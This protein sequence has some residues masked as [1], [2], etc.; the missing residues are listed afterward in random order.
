MDVSS[1]NFSARSTCRVRISVR[2]PMF[3]CPPIGPTEVFF[4]RAPKT[5]RKIGAR[6]ICRKVSKNIF[7]TFLTFFDVAPS[8]GPVCGPGVFCSCYKSVGPP[9]GSPE[10]FSPVQSVSPL[11]KTLCN[12]ETQIWLEMI[13]ARDA[14]SACFKG[15]RTT[16]SVSWAKTTWG[17]G[18]GNRIVR[19][20]GGKRTIACA[21][22]NHFWRAQKVGLVWSV[23]VHSKE[24]CQCVNNGEGGGNHRWGGPKLFLGRGFMVCFPLSSPPPLFFSEFVHFW[25]F[26]GKFWL[27]KIISSDGCFL[28]IWGSAGGFFAEKPSVCTIE[29]LMKNPHTKPQKFCRTSGAKP[30]F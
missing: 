6:E 11:V 27:K 16:C 19:F 29:K 2:N 15:S 12:F 18:G 3:R 1:A 10:V 7:D 22:Q 5:G 28:L 20:G 9:G 21:L 14:K 23:P 17:G 25:R 4:F 8:A 26:F 24:K 30:S 13:T